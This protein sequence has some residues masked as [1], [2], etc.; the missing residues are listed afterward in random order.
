M[1]LR[2]MSE[3]I[4]RDAQKP[5]SPIE[6]W[7]MAEPQGYKEKL[8][9]KGRTIPSTIGAQIYTDIKENHNSIF[10]KIK[11]KPTRFYLKDVPQNYDINLLD[12]QPSP[13]SVQKAKS[14]DERALHP[15]LSYYVYTF[16]FKEFLTRIKTDLNSKEIR[17]EK[18]DN[19][20]ETDE[21]IKM[22][23]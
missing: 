12:N 4:I 18:F 3:K 9:L 15:L 7:E 14:F 16:H 20:F 5:L 19:I 22:Y 6:I 10:I 13:K 11:T 23:K 1:N 2:E 21:L 17:K 8:N